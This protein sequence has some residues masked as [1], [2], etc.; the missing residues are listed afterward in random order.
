MLYFSFY[1]NTELH[2]RRA[3]RAESRTGHL[4]KCWGQAYCFDKMMSHLL[5][6][7]EQKTI[8]L[9]NIGAPRCP[10]LAESIKLS[11]LSPFTIFQSFS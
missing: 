1:D 9:Q 11:L 5:I 7:L 2:V 4:V 8:V 10:P 6:V 3:K